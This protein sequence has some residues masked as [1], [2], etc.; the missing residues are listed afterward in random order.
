M[1]DHGQTVV[2]KRRTLP[3]SIQYTLMMI[4]GVV[5]LILVR[6]LTPA[7]VFLARSGWA[8]TTLST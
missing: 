2:K 5:W 3:L 8:W 6:I 4:P 1:A 7:R